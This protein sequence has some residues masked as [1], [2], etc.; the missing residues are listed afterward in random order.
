[1]ENDNRT[2]IKPNENRQ[3]T[4]TCKATGQRCGRYAA[5]GMTVCV[6]HGAGGVNSKNRIKHQ[7][8][9]SGVCLQDRVAEIAS[10]P[11]LLNLKN[12]IALMKLCLQ[13]TMAKIESENKSLT[14]PSTV[15]TLNYLAN[16]ISKLSTNMSTIERNL[17]RNL[18]LI[19]LSAILM[20][21]KTIVVNSVQPLNLPMDQKQLLM[22]TMGKQIECIEIP[23]SK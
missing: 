8:K 17:T 5:P 9:Q 3:C 16:S 12:E 14:D 13:E 18:D 15:Q 4:A 2:F 10:D 23:D 11:D 1:M 7:L 21:L 6:M 20:K 22:E 19:M